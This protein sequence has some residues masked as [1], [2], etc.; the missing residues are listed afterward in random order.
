MAKYNPLTVIKLIKGAPCDDTYTDVIKFG[1]KAE[2]AAF[3]SGLAPWSFTNCSY[4][5]VNNSV[6]YPRGALSCRVP[7]IADN[8][9]DCNYVMF[10]NTSSN[11]KWFYAFIRKVNYISPENTEIIYEI[12]SYQTYQFDYTVKPS[13][14]LR[15]HP[16]D[17]QLFT[18]SQPEPISISESFV[19]KEDVFTY[20]DGGDNGMAWVLSNSE[21]NLINGFYDNHIYT[22]ATII[23]GSGAGYLAAQIQG[24]FTA[25]NEDKIIAVQSVPFKCYGGEIAPSGSFKPADMKEETFESSL[26]DNILNYTPKYKKCFSYPFCYL[27]VT[28]MCS[29]TVSYAYEKFG[30]WG[31]SN[32]NPVFTPS[33]PQFRIRWKYTYPPAVQVCPIGY[34]VC[35]GEE[36]WNNGFIIAGFPSTSVAGNGAIE[37]LKRTLDYALKVG[38]T[39]LGGGLVG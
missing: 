3:F 24:Y 21:A 17:D 1:S 38:L 13:M 19:N 20:G 12:D 11:S 31:L 30:I 36:N 33:A 18:N 4:Q 16:E 8:Y 34:E 32:E 28:D 35:I 9:Y 37:A 26:P 25:D 23:P 15:E 14:V 7:G 22:T 10:Q 5:R 29:N 27:K 6:A 2:Q 39:A